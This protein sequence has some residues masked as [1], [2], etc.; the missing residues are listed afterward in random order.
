MPEE[1]IYVVPLRAARKAP[2]HRRTPRAV[3]VVREFLKRHMKSENIKLNEGLNRKL[4]ERGIERTL[5]R[6]RLRVVKQDD[7]SVEAF[8][9]E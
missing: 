3:K 9:A 7:G 4:W 1:R 6:I 2:R 5:P 8:L